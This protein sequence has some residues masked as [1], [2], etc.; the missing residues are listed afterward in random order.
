[1][2]PIPLD[3]YDGPGNQAS[4]TD[5]LGNVVQYTYD[6]ANQLK[7]VVQTASPSA[8]NT[9]SYGYDPGGNLTGIADENNHITTTSFDQLYRLT[10][11]VLPDGSLTE[12]R[13]YDAAGNL[14]SLT[15]VT[16]HEK[17]TPYRSW[18]IDPSIGVRLPSNSMRKAPTRRQT[19]CDLLS[20]FF[21]TAARCSRPLS[22][23]CGM[24][25]T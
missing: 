23:D 8:N 21:Q 5:Q 4:V 10:A 6:A 1:M 9:N 20:K 16:N 17:L 7:T 25:L 2:I 13:Q 11:K 12:T 19:L 15:H 22:Q 18:R 3:T 14:T 24:C